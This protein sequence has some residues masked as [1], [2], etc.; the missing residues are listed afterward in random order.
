MGEDVLGGLTD[1]AFLQVNDLAWHLFVASHPLA[2]NNRR[3]SISAA[4]RAESGVA[5]GAGISN[6]DIISF[7]NAAT[8]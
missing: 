2:S 5:G 7:Q 3:L 6:P 4:L 1:H 8:I